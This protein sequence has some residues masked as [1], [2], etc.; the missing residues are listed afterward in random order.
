MAD[1][2]PKF[3]RSHAIRWPPPPNAPGPR[4]S[5]TN[6]AAPGGRCGIASSGPTSKPGWNLPAERTGKHRRPMLNGHF[7]AIPNAAF[8]LT[9][10]LVL[11]VT[12][13]NKCR[14]VC[15]SCN[16]RRTVETAAHLVES[17]DGLCRGSDGSRDQA[18]RGDALSGA[19]P[20]VGKPARSIRFRVRDL[21]LHE[22][23]VFGRAAGHHFVTR[24]DQSRAHLAIARNGGEAEQES[25]T[26]KS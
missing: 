20:A 4:P 25:V 6:A 16:T 9:A 23:A 1:R 14:G 26:W 17:R 5:A 2:A 22:G 13:A 8:S 19:L 21:L 15:P 7:A 3:N 12:S 18:R 11:T 24:R 10:S